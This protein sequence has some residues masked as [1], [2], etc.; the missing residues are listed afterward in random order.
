M[1]RRVAFAGTLVAVLAA[2]ATAADQARFAPRLRAELI[3]S[4]DGGPAVVLD[5]SQTTTER[6]LARATFVVPPEQ[7]L[8]L[9]PAGTVVG[10]AAVALVPTSGSPRTPSLLVGRLAVARPANFAGCVRQPT[11]ALE[12]LLSGRGAVG[13]LTLRLFVHVQRGMTR[14]TAC[15][16]RQDSL[17]GRAAARRVAIRF[18]RGLGAPPTGTSVWRG[19]FTPV[20]K[21]GGAAAYPAT[22]ESRG[23]VISPSFLTLQGPAT[24]RRGTR[25]RVHG[26][27]SL[28]DAAGG[29]FVRITAGGTVLGR[30]RTADSGAYAVRVRMPKRGSTIVLQARVSSRTGACGGR[31]VDAPAGCTSA[32]LGGVTSNVLRI[33]LR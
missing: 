10:D 19:L 27:L 18:I 20:G 26:V 3:R 1:V 28:G 15:L 6:G 24:A 21:G 32:T 7:K 4:P 25:V 29:R 13:R 33:R 2:A 8:R 23:I 11:N 14:I 5:V 16:P 12:A 9:P 30:A 31:S 22:T 17:P